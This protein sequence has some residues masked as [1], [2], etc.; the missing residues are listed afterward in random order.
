MAPKA[1]TNIFGTREEIA[2]SNEIVCPIP[3]EKE[4]NLVFVFV[5]KKLT[6]IEQVAKPGLL[7]LET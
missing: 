4:I 1:I 3:A 2:R 6:R 7:Q 5:E